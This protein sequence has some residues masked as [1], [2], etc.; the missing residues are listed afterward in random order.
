MDGMRCQF[1]RETAR[2]PELGL[3]AAHATVRD[4]MR[5]IRPI[6]VV[7]MIKIEHAFDRRAFSGMA[8]AAHASGDTVLHFAPSDDDEQPPANLDFDGIV[9]SSDNNEWISQILK[10]GKPCVNITNHPEAHAKVPMIGTDDEAIGR[11]AAQHYIDRGFRHFAFFCDPYVSYFFPRRDAF[12]KAL[13]EAGFSCEVGPPATVPNL[14]VHAQEWSEHAA[15]WLS[16]LPR[17]VAVFSPWDMIAREAMVACQLAQLRIPEDVSVIGVDDD[18]MACMTTWPPLS[19]I[20]TPAKRIGFEAV[21]LLQSMILDGASPP[22][23]PMLFPPTEVVVRGSSSETAVDD[24]EVA[25]AMNFI[26]THLAQRLSVDNLVEHTAISRRALER[27][28]LRTIGRTPMEEI[29]R[30]RVERAKRLLV[31]TDLS[32]AEVARRSGLVRLQ[33][34]CSVLK[35]DTGKTPLQFRKEAQLG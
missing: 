21:R 20:N 4:A 3:R 10:L 30:A 28:F 35:E 18:E 2:W 32:L 5:R 27:R 11:M 9:L 16:S 25:M 31:E 24:A 22:A 34:L 23:K 12:V 19:S 8:A 6:N 14:E 13:A 29:R 26:R 7:V 15:K 33:R 17:P 1:G